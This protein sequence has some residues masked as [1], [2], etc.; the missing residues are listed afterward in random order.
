MNGADRYTLVKLVSK[1]KILNFGRYILK[2]GIKSPYFL[3][4]TLLSSR[5]DLLETLIELVDKYFKKYM[6]L[7]DADKYIGILN[8]GAVVTIPLAIKKK[9]PFA[10]VSPEK[11]D[12]EVG[13]LETNEDI[14]L[15][16][17]MLSTGRTTLRIV[18]SLKKRYGVEIGKVFVVLDREE[19]G[20]KL[21]NREG[22]KV[23]RLAKIS[24]VIKALYEFGMINEEE[25]NLVVDHLNKFK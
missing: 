19:G 13:T 3:D 2:N 10:L 8:K 4:F 15:L 14:V 11:G 21:L 12:I 1:G 22:V 7:E 20:Y 5:I 23:Y 16:D 9:K 25:Y 24:D 6:E 17:D 18:D